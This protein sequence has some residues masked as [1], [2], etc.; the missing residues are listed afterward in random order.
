M[1]PSARRSKAL[2]E[3][4][5]ES[6]RLPPRYV[7]RLHE[8]AR[9]VAADRNGGDVEAAEAARNLFEVIRVAG[10]A[11]EVKAEVAALCDPAAP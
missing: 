3:R 8:P 4:L 10:V 2:I 5:G 6:S 9:F 1:F 7:V 11:G